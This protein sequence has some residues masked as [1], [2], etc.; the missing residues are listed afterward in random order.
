MIQ[1]SRHSLLLLASAWCALSFVQRATG[2]GPDAYLDYYRS[3]PDV[4]TKEVTSGAAHYTVHLL[5]RE[6][7]VI[8]AL[9]R[10]T[11]TTEEAQQWLKSK[12]NEVLLL[13]Q[14]GVP[15]NGQNEFLSYEADS[16]TFEERVKYYAFDIRKD[17]ALTVNSTRP[18][19][20]GDCHFERDFGL[21][22]TG[23][24]IIQTKLPKDAH[25][26]QFTFHDKIYGEGSRTV[27]FNANDI[28]STPRLKPPRK[29]NK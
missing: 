23:T 9:Q 29:W 25:T 8:Q 10:G 7:Q 19:A 14:I 2:V 12:E 20:M 4:F 16:S 22:P 17:M 3:K 28:R 5:T 24:L 27:E 1:R 21:S 11:I 18:L 6:I 26:L 15:A 13:V